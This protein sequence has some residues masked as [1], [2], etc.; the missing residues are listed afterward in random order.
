MNYKCS[1]TLI[2]KKIMT[3]LI[4]KTYCFDVSNIMVSYRIFEKLLG[5][6]NN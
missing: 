2:L 1:Q 5:L 4:Y 3:F 6:Y